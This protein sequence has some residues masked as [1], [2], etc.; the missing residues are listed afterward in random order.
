MTEA[1]CATIAPL[2]GTKDGVWLCSVIILNPEVGLI[3]QLI[4]KFLVMVRDRDSLR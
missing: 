3:L 1:Q 2:S 4:V